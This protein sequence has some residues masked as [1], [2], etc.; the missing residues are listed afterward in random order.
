[1]KYQNVQSGFAGILGLLL[2]VAL[3]GVGFVYYSG[4]NSDLGPQI[5]AAPDTHGTPSGNE[6][7][8]MKE[9]KTVM[10][11]DTTMMTDAGTYETYSPEK[12][13]AAK[14]VVV[15][16]FYAPWCPICRGLESDINAHLSS[17]PANFTILKVDYD[18]STAL[19]QKY[20]VTYQHTFVQVDTQGNLLAKW[21]DSTTLDQVL[22][23]VK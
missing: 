13:A 10:K 15:L 23:R 7:S 4:K 11:D 18:S 3:I 17:F 12:V 1:M 21:G 2:M 9:G 14:G 16:F 20:G 6:S 8:I 19:K 5:M 22:A